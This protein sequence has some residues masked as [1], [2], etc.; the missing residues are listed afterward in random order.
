MRCLTGNPFLSGSADNPA[1]VDELYSI[2]LNELPKRLDKIEAVLR[3]DDFEAVLKQ[4]HSLRSVTW[5]IGAL[6]SFHL[7][8]K[9]EQA[10]LAEDLAGVRGIRE[11]SHGRTGKGQNHYARGNGRR[12]TF[13][14]IS[15]EGECERRR[16]E[17]IRGL[18]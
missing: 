18:Q 4:M 7:V 15:P 1:F 2:F 3:L 5:T 9:V 11:A 6:S 10:A 14:L 17:A 12:E 13:S 16:L 8:E